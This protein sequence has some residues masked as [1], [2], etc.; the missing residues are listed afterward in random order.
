M[1]DAQDTKATEQSTDG[2]TQHLLRELSE[3][4]SEGLIESHQPHIQKIVDIVE[5]I[6]SVRDGS[7]KELYA[8]VEDL[9]ARVDNLDLALKVKKLE[10]ERDK[11]TKALAE[12]HTTTPSLESFLSE[13]KEAGGQ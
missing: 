10:A 11:L 2:S 8:R 1:N 7:I 3:R 9:T 12:A 5:D 4:L 13:S 6:I